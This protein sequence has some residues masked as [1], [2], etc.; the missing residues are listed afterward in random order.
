M[1]AETYRCLSLM[2]TESVTVFWKHQAKA[3]DI[4]LMQL[5]QIILRNIQGGTKICTIFVRLITSS[6]INQLSNF[7]HCQNQEKICN[8]I[9]T[10]NLT[11][12]QT[13]LYT[14]LWNVNVLKQQL[15]TRLL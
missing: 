9:M 5:V 8:N 15:K 11:T 7:F 3:N 13:C 10:K 12:P 1:P 2:T 6:N 4:Y 14:T